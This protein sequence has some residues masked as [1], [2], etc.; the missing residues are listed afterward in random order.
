MKRI[1]LLC[2][3]AILATICM[4][5]VATNALGKEANSPAAD[6]ALVPIEKTVVF[7][8]G[9][10]G[11]HTYRI[12]A[13]VRATNGDLLAFAEAR[14]NDPGDHG[15]IDIVLKRSSDDG[16]TWGPMTLVQDE[17]ENPT[18][19]VWIGNPSPVVDT[20]D[21]EHPGRVWLPFTRSNAA[22]FV[23]YSDDHGKTWAKPRDISKTTMKPEWNWCAAGPVHSIQLQQGP[24][25]GRL[26][27]PTDHKIN[28]PLSWG[29]HIVYSDDHGKTWK[30]GAS[31]TRPA[32]DPVHPNECVAVE[33]ADGRLYINAREHLGSSPETR[34]EAYSSDGGETFDAPFETDAQFVTPV[35]QNSA[36]R[37]SEKSGNE[38]QNVLVYSCPGDPK[39]RLDL[40]LMLSFDESETWPVKKLLHKGPVAYSDLVKLDDQ[41]VGVLYE[42]GEKL[43]DEIV[44][45][46][47]DVKSIMDEHDQ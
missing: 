24:H 35:V 10:D 37:F 44:F 34:V 29:S 1:Q 38:G 9:D 30:L 18:A 41:H 26:I 45:G 43:Y 6:S 47:V 21:P 11:Y 46:I 17:W 12:P 27:V 36:L 22:L 14:K 16:R 19:R 2:C 20:I 40:T 31:D 15:D 5:T 33:L 28:E 7:K 39:K 13:I 3:F 8:S 23:T 25:R 4:A 32:S 42:A